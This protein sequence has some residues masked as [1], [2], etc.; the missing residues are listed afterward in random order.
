MN[1]NFDE[2]TPGAKPK[3]QQEFINALKGVEDDYYSM[4]RQEVLRIMDETKGEV[5]ELICQKILGE[6]RGT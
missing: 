1:F 5:S 2:V 4:K 6:M 3:D